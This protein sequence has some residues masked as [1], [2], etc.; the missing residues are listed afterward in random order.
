[1]ACDR[2]ADVRAAQTQ[3]AMVYCGQCPG[4]RGTRSPQV[5]CSM[6]CMLHELHVRQCWVGAHRTRASIDAHRPR[7]STR[8]WVEAL[9]VAV[10]NCILHPS[11][12]RDRRNVPAH[13]EVCS[14]G[15]Q[16]FIHLHACM[17]GDKMMR[18]TLA[19]ARFSE[20]R[21]QPCARR[22]PGFCFR[23]SSACMGQQHHRCQP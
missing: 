8:C 5:L 20:R 9:R 13:R 4:G 7:A 14:L 2:T 16:T 11:V 1:M 18:H 19:Q 3:K 12:S 17:G 6:S 22:C 10:N 23:R 21:L 15:C